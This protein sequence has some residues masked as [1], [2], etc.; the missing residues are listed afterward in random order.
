MSSTS[1]RAVRGAKFARHTGT[2]G[3]HIQSNSMGGPNLRTVSH[4]ETFSCSF[5]FQLPNRCFSADS[6][7]IPKYVMLEL[8]LDPLEYVPS[9]ALC[10]LSPSSLDLIHMAAMGHVQLLN[11]LLI[12]SARPNSIEISSLLHVERSES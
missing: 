6:D 4:S 1:P 3:V 5:R 9:V 10:S 11:S 7:D 2:M 12:V 8:P